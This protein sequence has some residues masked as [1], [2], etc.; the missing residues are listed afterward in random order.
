MARIGQ[1]WR[2]T[3][4]ATAVEYAFV[5]P[6]LMLILMGTGY[7]GQMFYGRALLNGAVRQAARDATLENANTTALDQ[8]VTKVISPALPGVTVASTRKAYY[9]FSDIGRAEKWTDANSNGRC[10]NGEPY[11]DEN[12]DGSWNSDIGEAG[13]GTAGDIIVYTV[14]ASYSPMFNVPFMKSLWGKVSLTSSAVRR[15]QPW[16]AQ[17]A[18][19]SATR[20]CP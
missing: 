7:F 18:Y 20:T 13:N 2:D 1:I 19:G 17:V 14:T 11:T 9:D 8:S 16:A 6:I 10:D 5:L 12:G 15:N 4:G 3:R